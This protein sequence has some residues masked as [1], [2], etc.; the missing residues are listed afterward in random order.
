MATLAEIERQEE[1]LREQLEALSDG[2]RK[3]FYA[4]AEA[5]FKDPD[6]YA[7]LA[8]LFVSGLHHFYLKRW[9]R[10]LLDLGL[11]ALGLA[12]VIAGIVMESWVVG[13]AGLGVWIGV[14]LWELGYL[15]KS[16]AIVREYNLQQQRAILDALRWKS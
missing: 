7:T 11:N 14:S 9:R 2:E 15:F 3:Q 5:A 4:Q 10:G 13:L 12:L 6:T 16:Q 1:E 8:Y